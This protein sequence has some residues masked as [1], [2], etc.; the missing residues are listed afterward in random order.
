MGALKRATVPAFAKVNLGLEVLG[1][2]ADGDHELRTIFQSVALHDDVALVV[3]PG[4]GLELRC[5]APGV[6]TDERNL[7]WRAAA[8]LLRFTGL[9]RRVRIGLTKRIPAAGGLGGG[10]S[11]AAAVLFALDRLL[12]T[13][14]GPAGLVPL[15]RRLGADVAYFLFGGT[16]LGVARG[17]EIYPL[18]RQVDAWL[19]LCFPPTGASTAAVFRRIDA[20]LTPR[21]NA[22]TI[23]R[24]VSSDLTAGAYRL[25]VNDLE[26]AALEEV[27]ELEA[28]VVRIR[29]V[30][31][32][33]GAWG[34]LLSGSGSTYFGV[35]ETAVAA[36]DA[37]RELGRAGFRATSCR[38]VTGGR[39][40]RAWERAL[41]GEGRR[42]R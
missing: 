8:D 1:V 30:L 22:P 27:P 39:Y 41:T 37:A 31:R 38:T 18:A 14:L 2:R 9:R 24:F 5:D 11:N 36:R 29:G 10:S 23:F 12:G 34:T 25:L 20:G 7:A 17:D 15:A 3:G 42:A 21:E 4:D 26:A 28:Q 13:G 33:R 6:P 40:R 32:S 19:T 35:F 16:A